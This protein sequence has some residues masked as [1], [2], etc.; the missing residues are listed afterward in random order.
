[1]M[2]KDPRIGARSAGRMG[3]QNP[4]CSTASDASAK[5]G[6]GTALS[7]CAV[8]V[9]SRTTSAENVTCRR[10]EEP[11]RIGFVKNASTTGG[12]TT[13]SPRH[14]SRDRSNG[15][16]ANAD[17]RSMTA[18]GP[19]SSRPDPGCRPEEEGSKE[20]AEHPYHGRCHG[21]IKGAWSPLR[22]RKGKI[23]RS[24][25]SLFQLLL[26]QLARNAP[27]RRPVTLGPRSSQA[28]QGRT[29]R[30]PR[31]S[32][33]TAPCGSGTSKCWTA[34][35]LRSPESAITPSCLLDPLLSGAPPRCRKSVC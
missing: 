2:C 24:P 4:Q 14:L 11:L 5:P 20:A 25:V 23:F 8:Y 22:R 31:I 28:E 16:T 32:A 10:E 9:C 26:Q 3:G 19:D 21:K 1:M 13:P 15:A 35:Y 18:D 12:S 7:C 6:K 34:T 27:T 33:L 30:G 29:L 17:R